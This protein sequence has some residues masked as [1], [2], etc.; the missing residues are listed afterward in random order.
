MKQ[1]KQYPRDQ[2]TDSALQAFSSIFGN[3]TSLQNR[4]PLPP[5]IK[6][7]YEKSRALFP[8]GFGH[9]STYATTGAVLIG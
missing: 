1:W 2:L 7:V 4:G 3:L 5:G 8:L 6:G 9:T